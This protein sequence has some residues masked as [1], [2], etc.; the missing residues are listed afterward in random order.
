MFYHPWISIVSTNDYYFHSKGK[1][2][3]L[4]IRI[5]I[6]SS[7][8][9]MF[10]QIINMLEYSYNL[11]SIS[12]HHDIT[13]TIISVTLFR[14]ISINATTI[15]TV[16]M[17]VILFRKDIHI[18]TIGNINLISYGWE[19]NHKLDS[20]NH[21]GLDVVRVLVPLAVLILHLYKAWNRWQRE[22]Y[23]RSKWRFASNIVH[24]HLA[25]NTSRKKDGLESACQSTL[26]MTWVTK[27][28]L[29][30]IL[31]DIKYYSPMDRQ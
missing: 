6:Y 18:M 26:N 5:F 25:E 7:S 12:F 27:I 10:W 19:I 23:L 15:F 4:A 22:R 29:Q 11:F 13:D 21:F 20:A 9:A 3:K 8:P 17:Y 2:W 24:H 1:Y 14:Y 16:C 31:W 30:S 28:P